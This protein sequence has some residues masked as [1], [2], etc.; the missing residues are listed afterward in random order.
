MRILALLGSPR[1]VLIVLTAVSALYMGL[2]TLGNISDYGTNRAFLE[3]VLAMDTT[4]GSASTKWRAI[5]DQRLVTA[6]YLAVIV[7]ESL[8][9]LILTIAFF[10]WL[11]GTVRQRG[12]VVARQLSICGWLMQVL[13]FGGGFIAVGGEWFEMWQ[14]AKWN[15]TQAAFQNLLIPVAGLMLAHVL[16]R[17]W[18]HE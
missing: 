1:M 10:W 3:H 14:S 13:L 4:F 7:W 2:V 16:A 5:T 6:A 8:I 15:G 11:R 9:A 17:E 12:A 18:Q